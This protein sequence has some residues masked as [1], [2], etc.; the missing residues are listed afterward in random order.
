M[1]TIASISAIA[2][3]PGRQM[4]VATMT[5]TRRPDITIDGTPAPAG[6]AALW[7]INA[8]RDAV[9]AGAG[10][11]WDHPA[12]ERARSLS[13]QMGARWDFSTWQDALDCA[14][15]GQLGGVTLALE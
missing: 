13:E 4:E 10:D 5:R 3:A 11:E 15:S 8:L 7:L 12:A 1:T 2:F 14:E 9:R 6:L